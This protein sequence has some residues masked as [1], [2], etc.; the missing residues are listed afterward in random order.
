[1]QLFAAE[2]L[3]LNSQLSNLN[4]FPIM[5]ALGEGPRQRRR[6]DAAQPRNLDSQFP[7]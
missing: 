6:M 7:K 5:Q 3:N 2:P 4:S 1:M